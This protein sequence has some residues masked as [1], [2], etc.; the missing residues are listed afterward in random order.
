MPDFVRTFLDRLAHPTVVIFLLTSIGYSIIWMTKLD[1]RVY[2]LQKETEANS[3]AI[4][5]HLIEAEKWKRKI[6]LNEQ[7]IDRLRE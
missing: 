3:A 6:L 2:D 1:D 7:S 4:K 5:E